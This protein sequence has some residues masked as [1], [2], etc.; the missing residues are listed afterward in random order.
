MVPS[1]R[2]RIFTPEVLI[3]IR[4]TGMVMCSLGI[5]WVRIR[6]PMWE[7]SREFV[8]SSVS[9]KKKKQFTRNRKIYSFMKEHNEKN[10]EIDKTS[11]VF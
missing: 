1:E 2:P 6:F 5:R 11:K 9:G 10:Y 4:M 8:N 7:M 3:G